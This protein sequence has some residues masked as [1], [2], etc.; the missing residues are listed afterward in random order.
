MLV[1]APPDVE[2]ITASVSGVPSPNVSG[3]PAPRGFLSVAN[4]LGPAFNL[5]VGNFT[6]A[7]LIVSGDGS[8]AYILA[9]D[10]TG[11]RLPFI[12]VFNINAQTSSSIS[13]A[14]SA[15]PLSA[16]VSPAG[17]LLFVGASDG[18]VHVIDTA[19]GSDLQQV[20]FPFPT[21]ELCF[22]PGSPPT[23]VPATT[24][25]ITAATQSGSNTTYT[26]TLTSGPALQTGQ[27]INIIGMTDA[28]DNGTFIITIA[29]PGSGTFTVINASGA[30]VSGQNG[31]GTV[32][33]TCNPDLV[34]AKP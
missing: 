8:T 10:L 12:I 31:I 1:L 17:D 27:S 32:P 14:N 34:V 18:T 33:I 4:T 13:L 30:A 5:G 6:P 21:N 20:T 2:T 29:N 25:T 15:T 7:Q 23:Q 22:G 3:C 26:Y 16:A 11:A 19:S 28:S 24:V 9:D